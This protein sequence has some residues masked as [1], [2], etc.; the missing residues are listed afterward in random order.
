[1]QGYETHPLY[2]R[3]ILAAERGGAGK[4]MLALG[5]LAAWRG[6]GRECAAFKKG[7]DY[8]DSAWLSAAAGRPC[9]SLDVYLMGDRVTAR[10]FADHGL[11]AGLNLIEGNRGLYD[12][13]DPRGS[14]STAELAKL[15][16]CPVVLIVTC[17]KRTCTS[18]AVVLGCRAMDPRVRIA[19][20]I[21]N[22][23]ATARQTRVVREA[24]ETI[25]G[26]KVYGAVP[27]LDESDLRERHLGL[28]PPQELARPADAIEAAAAMARTY[29]DLDG[30]WRVAWDAPSFAAPRRCAEAR[31]REAAG[32]GG[33]LRVGYFRDEA[34]HFYYPENLEA[35][36]RQG[37]TLIPIDALRANGLP[38]VLDGLYIGG[39]FPEERAEALA[40][41]EPLRQ[42]VRRRA[43]EGLP[44]YAE[45][46]GLIYLGDRL[47]TRRGE[48]PMAGIFPVSF[49]L[50][51]KPQGHG[52]VE[53]VTTAR[54]P[55]MPAGTRMRGHEF[56]Y[57]RPVAADPENLA[58]GIT[59]ERGVGIHDGRDGLVYKNTIGT[60]M[61]LHAL[62]ARDWAPAWV[63]QCR[64]HTPWACAV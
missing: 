31:R 22:Q 41:N 1:M 50:E 44:I 39:G 18:A 59:L 58:F 64:R 51:P 25:T 13:V 28:K 12:G 48:F 42:A 24:V 16:D 35:L 17:E 45:C 8:I 62:G 3:L 19:G 9:R 47:V 29:L 32:G 54:H 43:G 61:H 55:F 27:R 56:H 36:E 14:F 38:D 53:A 63:R 49:A 10:S 15:L 37:A 46:G 57:T 11:I 21:L 30:L 7:P 52:Y 40:A 34:F 33:T 4:T 6:Q 2:P 60:Y 5:L 26:L 23:V 20:V